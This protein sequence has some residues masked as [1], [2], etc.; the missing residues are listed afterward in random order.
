MRAISSTR[1]VVAPDAEMATSRASS[2]VTVEIAWLANQ[3]ARNSRNGASCSAISEKP[4]AMAW[5]PPASRTPAST[6]G[7]DRRA[8]V[9][10]DDRAGR[11][12]AQAAL[13]TGHKGRLV[14]AVLEPPGHD[15]D[16]A[17]SASL[18]RPPAGT[19][20][21]AA[22]AANAMAS[23]RIIASIAW[24]SRL[25]VSRSCASG[26]AWARFAADSSSAPSVQRPT[27]PP[28]LIRG[29]STKPRW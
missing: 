19:A 11:A 5:P 12:A 18:R 15:A 6:R 26:S 1:S 4:A 25:W 8:D 7:A 22:A 24:R 20:R 29:P 28:A 3:A 9:D 23:S 2:G 14:E 16:H 27:R 17:R 10:P 13:E 21:S